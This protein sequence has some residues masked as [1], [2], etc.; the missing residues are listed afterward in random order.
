MSTIT[1]L[2]HLIKTNVFG[3]TDKIKAFQKPRRDNRFKNK[4]K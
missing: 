3:I 2:K 4:R 1:N